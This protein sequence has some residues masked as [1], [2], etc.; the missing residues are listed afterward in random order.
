MAKTTRKDTF[1]QFMKLSCTMSVANAL[2]FSEVSLGLAAFD[3]MALIIHR[4]EYFP[5]SGVLE[6][7]TAATDYLEIAITGSDSIAD[8][9]ISRPEVYDKVFVERVDYGTAAAA[10]MVQQPIVHDYNA[11]PGG[12]QI[13]PAS[14]VY[15]GV[16]TQGLANPVTMSAR[17]WFTI[18]QLQMADYYELAQR[19]RVLS[20]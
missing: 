9:S 20:T 11:Y 16:D 8:L 17:L 15:I 13:I 12:G 18:K 5:G 14:D 6:L 19:L 1:A 3:Y 10:E 2:A 7:M 4:I